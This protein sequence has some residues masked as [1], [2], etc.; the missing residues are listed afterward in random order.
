MATATG[1]HLTKPRI[2]ALVL[3]STAGT[4]ALV[5]VAWLLLWFIRQVV[6]EEP[7]QAFF[8]ASQ[9]IG[10]EER[11][12]QATDVRMLRCADGGEVKPEGLSARILDVVGQPGAGAVV[13][14]VSAAAVGRGKEARIGE[15]QSLQT[16][17]QDVAKATQRDVVLALDVA[18]LDSDRDLGIF[19]NAPYA[20]L[21]G[22][23]SSLSS[24]DKNVWVLTSAAPAQKTWIA[25]GLGESVFA[26]YLRKGLQDRKEGAGGWAPRKADQAV[27]V[28][29]LH[30]FVLT[31]VSKWAQVHRR[32]FQ[33]PMLL[34]V[35]GSRDFLLPPMPPLRIA[36]TKGPELREGMIPTPSKAQDKAESKASEGLTVAEDKERIASQSPTISPR[37]ERRN[38]LLAEWQK[39]D[40]MLRENS[41]RP[42]RY[43]PCG[44][45][46]YQ[47]ALLRAERTL[48][49][50]WREPGSLEEAKVALD[51]AA[52]LRGVVEDELKNR[53]KAEKNFPFS[54]AEDDA[55]GKKE[56]GESLVFLTGKGP[57]DFTP[58]PVQPQKSKD[59]AAKEK[60][61]P[62]PP[63]W[64]TDVQGGSPEHYLELQLPV[65]TYR[66]TNEFSVPDF[67][68]N[69][70]R[71]SILRRLV[72]V[73][74]R[75]EQSLARDRRG[76]RWIEPIIELGDGRR[77][78][79]QDR[80]FGL[81][82]NG[83]EEAREYSNELNGIAR[84][85]EA[86]FKVI[87]T[88]HDARN[89]WEQI[90]A[91]LPYLAEWAIRSGSYSTASASA[92]LGL[93]IPRS[94]DAAFRDVRK[95]AQALHKDLSK[96]RGEA[97]L[98]KI[99]E[100]PFVDLEQATQDAQ[101]SFEALE[102]E[103]LAASSPERAR[104]WLA[105]DPVLRTPLV[106]SEERKILIERILNLEEAIPGLS[107]ED[108]KPADLGVGNQPDRGF[109]LRAAGLAQLALDLSSAGGGGRRQQ[110]PA[111]N[112]L[113]EIWSSI[114]KSPD[115]AESA[116][117]GVTQFTDITEAVRTLR[118]QELESLADRER[119]ADDIE[120]DLSA[121]DN[122]VR[123]LSAGEIGRQGA[124][125]LDR[126]VSDLDRFAEY[127]SL[128]FHANRLAEDFAPS[129]SDLRK[130]IDSV[131]KSLRITQAPRRQKLMQ[132]LRI[133]V[134]TATQS[135][136]GGEEAGAGSGLSPG[137][138][139]HRLSIG[140][141]G[142][143]RFKLKVSTPDEG[144][145]Q[146]QP[147]PTGQA[148]VGVIARE[149]SMEISCTKQH[150]DI[151][152][153]LVPVPTASTPPLDFLVR[154]LIT[155]KE[156]NVLKLE[157][158]LFYRGRVDQTCSV[159][160]DVIPKNFADKILVK[161]Q[162]DRQKLKNEYGEKVG[163]QI[164][165]QFTVHENEG[166]MHK[167][168]DLPYVVT[169][170]NLT[171][172]NLDIQYQREL[173]DDAGAIYKKLDDLPVATTLK[174]K[175]PISLQHTITSLDVPLGKP[176]KLRVTVLDAERK[177]LAKP[178][179]VTFQQVTI[180][181]Y[182]KIEEEFD[183]AFVHEPGK[184]PEPCFLVYFRRKKDDP[185]TEPIRASELECT[186]NGS[187][188]ILSDDYLLWPD[189][190]IIFHHPARDTR[191]LPWTG[192][193]ERETVKPK[194]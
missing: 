89:T 124:A 70:F 31:H 180:E 7:V 181:R 11:P 176:K 153:C 4:I 135:R 172:R 100:E 63:R 61:E 150:G 133:D 53:I 131:G 174:P 121:A 69:E 71:G 19:G 94:V 83:V 141:D 84:N 146:T 88:F 8:V 65:W 149:K 34:K 138:G 95:L 13:V 132:S 82:G 21:E 178:L 110:E 187:K 143:T 185:V 142:Q 101:A 56:V 96:E 79:V 156:T 76:L 12:I 91:D 120:S 42:Y 92:S 139:I 183:N 173:L 41:P 134:E 52:R 80:L 112:L 87:N 103:F 57:D 3:E 191:R 182:M 145:D 30:R 73:R 78:E 126:A 36:T 140:E 166:C 184:P 24:G 117:K 45:R 85:Y 35:G 50:T 14:Y 111:Q 15:T 159:P 127:K 20:G 152:G 170:E 40:G 109:W 72:E 77:R 43:L 62:E 113:T 151:P 66:F 5:L 44:W 67:F 25:E 1:T 175:E 171:F 97:F 114:Q 23:V 26:Y 186:I 37:D 164:L 158:K 157:A 188:A 194:E 154:Q 162:Q 129:L 136:P 118:K 190:W 33:T 9:T 189:R 93:R 119:L 107:P 81:S 74:S 47:A 177:P 39:H 102:R 2:S 167:D 104:D 17:I 160:L 161:T 59:G 115:S 98:K 10:P 29:G 169:I 48:R 106:P 54:P 6:T 60:N 51:E 179:E 16:L 18:Q 168:K 116:G 55:D 125:S 123:F 108:S 130:L 137:E 122:V 147:V 46:S 58:P 86:A 28:E 155:T 75:A 163:E 165:D 148:F 27:S 99:L 68:K 38:A 105:L 144:L 49:A 128:I 90:G 32:A 193:I 192:R 64:L 22:F